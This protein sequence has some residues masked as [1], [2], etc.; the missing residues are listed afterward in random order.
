MSIPCSIR[1]RA[2]TANLTSL[3]V[4]SRSPPCCS[5]RSPRGLDH[6][7]Q[8][9]F[10]HDQIVFIIDPDLGAR[11]LAEQHPVTRPDIEPLEFAALVPGTRTDGDDLALLRLL[12]GGVRNDDATGGPGFLLNAADHDA[13]MEWT[14]LH[15]FPSPGLVDA[16]GA[17]STPTPR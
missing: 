12:L 7:Q 3:A 10:L 5:I 4:M 11:P 15:R 1:S 2:S 13:I 6:A 16:A 17:I 14:E 8:V 9:G